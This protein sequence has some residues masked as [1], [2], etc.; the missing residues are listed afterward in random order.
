[1]LSERALP[2]PLTYNHRY[3]QLLHIENKQHR[4]TFE[5]RYQSY[6]FRPQ[7]GHSAIIL[8]NPSLYSLG[9]YKF[10]FYSQSHL[11]NMEK[12]N[13]S[14]TCYN[15]LKCKTVIENIVYIKYR[16]FTRKPKIQF[17]NFSFSSICV[18]PKKKQ[19]YITQVA[20]IKADA[21]AILAIH[22]HVITNNDRLSVTHNDYNT[23]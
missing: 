12:K 23:W 17:I 1:M 18:P 9:T 2:Q 5:S 11:I 14:L 16:H 20:W 21:K 6:H 8:A 3:R 13:Q 15:P 4:S 22:E 19:N 7:F 10:K